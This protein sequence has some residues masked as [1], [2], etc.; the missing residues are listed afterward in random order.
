MGT[1]GRG[2]NDA[3]GEAGADNAL[4]DHRLVEA[5]LASRIV[6]GQA[7]ADARTGRAA[8]HLA[9][10]KDTSSQSFCDLFIGQD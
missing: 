3:T 6:D 1:E 5:N 4:D 8:I 7:P 9:L 2:F 10:G